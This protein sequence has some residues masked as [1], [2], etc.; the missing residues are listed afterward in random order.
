MMPSH[1]KRHLQI[2]HQSTSASSVLLVLRLIAGTAFVIHGWGKMQNPLSWMGPQ[3]SVPSIFQ[4]LAAISEFGGGLGWIFGF[5][6]PIASLGIV[7]TMTVA[8]LTHLVVMKDPFV[9][10][11]GGGSYELALVYLGISLLFLTLGA[12]KFSL[13]AKIFGEKNS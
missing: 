8:V 5:L 6:T 3:A 1:L 11:K 10:L 12:G 9:N 2:I 13:D 4:F 7:S